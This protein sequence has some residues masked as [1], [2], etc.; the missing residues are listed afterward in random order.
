M[1]VIVPCGLLQPALVLQKRRRLGEKDAKGAQDGILDG[2]S[3]VWPLLAM[4]RQWS[5]PSV[6]DALEGIE[7]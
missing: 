7:V 6:Q 2:V 4:V 3:G 5:D 1:G